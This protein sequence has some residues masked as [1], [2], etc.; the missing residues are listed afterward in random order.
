MLVL[1]LGEELD[2]PRARVDQWAREASLH[3]E[4]I[5]GMHYNPLSQKYRLGA[6]VDVNYIV[7]Y[8]KPLAS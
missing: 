7:H 6:G 8:S 1:K 4:A 3:F 2:E 5:T